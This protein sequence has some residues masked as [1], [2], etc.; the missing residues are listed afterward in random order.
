MMM[1][2]A[3]GG[4]QKSPRT[5]FILPA[6]ALNDRDSVPVPIR[7]FSK[8]E[9]DPMRMVSKL[10]LPTTLFIPDEYMIKQASHWLFLTG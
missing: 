4:S 10:F 6:R 5:P 9:I 8:L 3:D 7:S 2:A 1:A